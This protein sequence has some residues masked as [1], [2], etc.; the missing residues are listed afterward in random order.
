MPWGVWRCASQ[1]PQWVY[2]SADLSRNWQ[3]P[4]SSTS[5]GSSLNHPISC[6]VF[7]E[8]RLPSVPAK[9]SAE[10][11]F[12]RHYWRSGEPHQFVYDAAV[13]SMWEV[14]L[15]WLGM[16]RRGGEPGREFGQSVVH[17][18]GFGLIEY[19]TPLLSKLDRLGTQSFNIN[20]VFR[21]LTVSFWHNSMHFFQHGSI[22]LPI[23]IDWHTLI[24][25]AVFGSIVSAT[26]PGVM[27]IPE[28]WDATENSIE[29]LL[30]CSESMKHYKLETGV[31]IATCRSGSSDA[32]LLL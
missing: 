29:L 3:M 7:R 6:T 27:P 1:H 13:S 5:H 18:E 17:V 20:E 4:L 31:D 23:G 14:I 19:D 15:M 12:R 22:R 24:T 25:A 21:P 9:S 28:N 16:Y 11:S 2:P 32:T 26:S 30:A 8:C 10:T